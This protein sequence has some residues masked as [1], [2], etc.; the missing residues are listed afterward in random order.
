MTKD[1][2]RGLWRFFDGKATKRNLLIAG[3]LA[4]ILLG[5][6]AW[7]LAA[8]QDLVDQ[9]KL[10]IFDV[11]LR[12]SGE[13]VLRLLRALGPQGGEHYRATIIRLDF[14]FPSIV[15]VLL[16]L[17]LVAAWRRAE[18]E[19]PHFLIALPLLA[20]VSDFIENAGILG[21][22]SEYLDSEEVSPGLVRIASAATSSKWFGIALTLGAILAPFARVIATSWR[23]LIALRVPLAAA[24]LVVGLPFMSERVQTI[25]G[26]LETAKPAYLAAL[27]FIALVAGRLIGSSGALI[28]ELAPK[29][30][31]LPEVEVPSW[32]R[33]RGRW[34]MSLFAVLGLPTVIFAAVF[35]RAELALLE[36]LGAVLLGLMA[37]VLLHGVQVFLA[38]HLDRPQ[39]LPPLVEAIF[40][41]I[42]KGYY[43]RDLE[44]IEPGHLRALLELGLFVGIYLICYFEGLLSLQ[45]RFLADFLEWTGISREVSGLALPTLGYVLL[46]VV[47]LCSFLSALTFLLDRFH[48]PLLLAF[49]LLPGRRQL[50]AA[51]RS[52]LRCCPFPA[53]RA[54]GFGRGGRCSVV[55]PTSRR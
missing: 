18:G 4:I 27:T 12:Y 26:M 20:L 50:F 52:F 13:D 7:R 54:R 5:A 49:L 33:R 24:V 21:L 43:D 2:W 48:V 53:G 37:F 47:L 3:V 23:W 19:R 14:F 8:L 35:S 51:A 29:R 45:P 40:E 41:K 17:L 11:Q 6:F 38:H 22:I 39:S 31:N 46:L 16:S 32:L 10:E 15:W 1:R 55:V 42:G 44:R 28:L 34:H 30:Y 25:H 9:E 36:V